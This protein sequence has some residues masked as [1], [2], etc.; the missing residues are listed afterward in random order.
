MAELGIGTNEGAT[1]IGDTLNDEKVLGTTHI[2][3]GDNINYG[4]RVDSDLHLDCVLT[5]A[6]LY[7]DDVLIVDKGNIVV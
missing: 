1:I 4:G 6:S 7:L 5:N 3:L 2:A